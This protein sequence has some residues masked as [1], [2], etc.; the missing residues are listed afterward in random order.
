MKLRLRENSIRLR[1]LQTEV[2]RLTETGFVAETITF[3]KSQ[4]FVYR[5]QISDEAKE[6]SAD[7]QNGEITIEI[8][9]NI[10]DKWIN[11]GRVGLQTE[12][13]FGGDKPLSILIEKDF[14]C[15]ERPGDTDNADAFPHPKMTC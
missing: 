4:S 2:R 9:R 12:Q 15:V 3:G 6:I 14:V 1:L 11:T 10:V 5:L 8:P 7:F 13:E